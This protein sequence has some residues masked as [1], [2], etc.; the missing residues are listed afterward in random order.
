MTVST[1]AARV[2]P[3]RKGAT[4]IAIPEAANL[5]QSSLV[6]ALPWR[7]REALLARTALARQHP[8]LASD[9]G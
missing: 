2:Q 7:W 8:K 5:M 3:G 1:G 9:V 4:T 6:R